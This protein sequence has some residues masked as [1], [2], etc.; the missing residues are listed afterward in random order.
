[1]DPQNV[2]QAFF[3]HVKSLLPPHVSMVDEIATLLDISTDS[4][5]RRIRGEKAI[6]LEELQKLSIKFKISL[7]Q[8]LHLQSSSFIFSGNLA[9]AASFTYIDYL[10]DLLQ[11]LQ[12]MNSFTHRHMYALVKDI[13][14]MHHFQMPALA[15]FRGF[16]WMKSILHYDT[17]RGKK[18]TVKETLPEQAALAHKIVDAYCKIPTTEIWNIESVNSTIRQ[19]RFYRDAQCFESAEDIAVLYSEVEQLIEHLE[20]QAELGLK[21]RAGESPKDG[22]ASYTMLNNELILGDNTFFVELDNIHVTYI[23][24]SVI[25]FMATRDEKYNRY[26]Y[27]SLQNLIR[28]STQISNVGEKERSRFFNRIREK[29]KQSAKN[30]Y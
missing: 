8:L 1:M 17:Y 11:Q 15:A 26:M 23:N 6:T 24:H 10:H 14:P 25:N 22:A 5:Y 12:Y 18:F 27:H 4:A 19:I 20:R 29:I 13:I 21:F 16:F 28:K 3:L 7:D 2:Q 30:G 9:S